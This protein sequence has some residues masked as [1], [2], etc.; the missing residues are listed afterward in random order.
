MKGNYR[1]TSIG[2]VLILEFLIYLTGVLF[3][4]NWRII[5][6]NKKWDNLIYPGVKVA[7]VDL[8]GRTLEDSKDLIKSQY[9]DPLLKKNISVV[10]N[11]KVYVL[12]N[13]KLITNYA[14]DNAI[15][16]A[17]NF[18]KDLP[19][20]KKNKIVRQGTKQ[21]Y[22][23]VFSYDEN[24]LREF[25]RSISK[26]VNKEPVNASIESTG[27]GKIEVKTGTK[28]CILQED[29]LEENIKDKINSGDIGNI[30]VDESVKETKARITEDKLSS[31]DTNI[32]SFYT[33]FAFSS[34][35]RSHN[36]EL[37]SSL[38]NGKLLLPGEIFSFN[39]CVGERTKD[40]GFEEAPVI[41]GD[42]L[43][44]GI[45]GGICQVSSTLYNAVLK[46]GI[47][48]IERAHHSLPASYVELGL[49]ATVDWNNI[50]FK[51]KNTLNYP[52]YIEAYVENKN[53]YINIYSNSSLTKK[54]Y[55]IRNSIYEKIQ[56][57]TQTINS[58]DLPEGYVAI[59]QKGYDGYKVKTIRDVYEKGV[60]ISSETISDDFYKPVSSIISRGVKK[61]D[62]INQ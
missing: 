24:Y 37:A 43:D 17:F 35:E 44:V 19:F 52:I 58:P 16:K 30:K 34:D 27:N 1:F 41:I 53:L 56:S 29:K 45:G 40:R 50:D 2:K 12:Q 10:G 11:E 22:D 54:K 32:A 51:F 3:G 9:I 36:I 5:N 13:S 60:L 7:C 62:Y 8:S 20:Y 31:I 25:I 23:I 46:A 55:T 14:I 33:S 47:K 49:D 15:D 28:G 57:S 4:L 18:G 59:E 48:P 42:K 26:D 38:I 61:N 39:D 6:E 21:E